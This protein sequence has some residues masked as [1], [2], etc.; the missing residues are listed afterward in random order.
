MNTRIILV[1]T[2]WII[3]NLVSLPFY[4]VWAE[5]QGQNQ[6]QAQVQQPG[7]ASSEGLGLAPANTQAPPGPA[8]PVAGP[9]A[10]GQRLSAALAS[11]QFTIGDLDAIW[12]MRSKL[13]GS[14]SEFARSNPELPDQ[15]ATLFRV[16]QILAYVGHFVLVRAAPQVRSDAFLL[17]AQIA[18][19]ARE[20]E[21]KKV[22]GHYWY[23]INLAGH[24]MFEGL[25]SSIAQNDRVLEALDAAVQIAPDYF[26][27]GPLRARGRLLIKAPGFPFSVGDTKRALA[28]LKKAVDRSPEVRVNHV[29]LAEAY[30]ESDQLDLARDSLNKANGLA[31]SFGV[32]EEAA[33]GRRMNELERNLK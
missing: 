7:D 31:D 5:A 23:A 28:D 20:L 29:Y 4:P 18:A 1:L 6:N 14:L 11:R 13:H 33:I 26:F 22:E 27:A 21:P 3:L 2:L 24:L 9:S 8:S 10:T 32:A 30:F 15:Y 19:R 16:S 25:L 17:G 12:M